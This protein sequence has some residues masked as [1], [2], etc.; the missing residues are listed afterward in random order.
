M[1]RH[2]LAFV[3]IPENWKHSAVETWQ[4]KVFTLLVEECRIDR[5]CHD[6]TIFPWSSLASVNNYIVQGDTKMRISCSTERCE[7][8]ETG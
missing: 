5:G 7:E 6:L 8:K 2:G 4:E 1:A 3:N